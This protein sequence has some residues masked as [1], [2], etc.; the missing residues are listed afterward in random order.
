MDGKQRDLTY[1]VPRS[2]NEGAF[3]GVP[4]FLPM[5]PIVIHPRTNGTVNTVPYVK[6]T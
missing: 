1:M 2:T 4:S 5:P 3:V 6:G